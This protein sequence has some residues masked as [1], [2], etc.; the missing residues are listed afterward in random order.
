MRSPT[1]ARLKADALLLLASLIWGTAFVAQRLVGQQGGVHLFNGARFGL[2]AFLLWGVQRFRP[3]GGRDFWRWAGV[4]GALLFSGSAL[5]QAGLQYTTAGNA[6]FITSLYTVFVPLLL[7][8]FWHEKP[9]L[10]TVLAVAMAVGGAYLLSAGGGFKAQ[11]GD[12]LE[13]IGAVFWAGHVILLGKFARRYRPLP[14]AT[15][16]FAVTAALSL[17]VGFFLEWPLTVSVRLMIPAVLYT[18]IFSVAIAYTLQVW[19]QQ[20]TP[21]TDAALILSLE[22]VFALLSGWLVLGESL[23]LAQGVGCALIFGGVMLSQADVLFFR[24][25]A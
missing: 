12:A 15:A 22:S 23:S 6:G 21:P 25:R 1:G 10:Y 19:G 11:R 4:A 2:A 14:F 24:Q 7:F 5:Q 9:A 17:A 8:F 16:Q 18:G 13:I 3:L 20:H